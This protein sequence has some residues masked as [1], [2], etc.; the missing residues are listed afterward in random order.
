MTDHPSCSIT[1][2][3]AAEQSASEQWVHLLPKGPAV[4]RDGRR[5]R[6]DDPSAIVRRTRAYAGRAPLV[7]DYEHQ[8]EQAKKNGQA[9]PAAGWLKD[10]EVREDGIWGLVEWT[11]RARAFIANRE[12]RFLSSVFSAARDGR[13]IQ[14]F[15][16]AL[17][18]AP[19]LEL[20]ALARAEDFMDELTELRKLLGLP[21][22]ADI[23]AI[24][25]NVSDLLK[26]QASAKPDPSQYVPIAEFERVTRDL[27]ARDQG[28]ALAKAEDA[29][30]HAI[31]HGQLPP[32]LRDWGVSLCTV[33]KPA[34][35]QFVD[36]T[37]P[38]LASLFKRNDRIAGP[39]PRHDHG[40]SE[41]EM[42]VCRELGHDPVEFAKHVK[43]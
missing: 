19:A 1:M 5:W 23:P 36:R 20:T 17:T 15:H 35:Q 2:A 21:E 40:F 22:E 10:F 33:N 25:A 30:D 37:S 6:V 4:A 16:A 28:V 27:N 31:E 39:K 34:F 18:N 24:T 8:T 43:D 3:L 14:L 32:Y 12:Y 41:E 13:V 9:A 7:V 26:A 29:V 42:A 38:A 11:D